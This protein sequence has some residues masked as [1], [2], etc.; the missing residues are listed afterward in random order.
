MQRDQHTIKA[1][2]TQHEDGQDA[3]GP[4]KSA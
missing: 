3:K 2:V 4:Q 1:I